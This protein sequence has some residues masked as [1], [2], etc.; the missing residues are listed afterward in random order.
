[1]ASSQRNAVV[2]KV[3]KFLKR[4]LSVVL[5]KRRYDQLSCNNHT[6]ESIE[7]ELN[8]ALEAQLIQILS[9]CNAEAV[10]KSEVSQQLVA[11]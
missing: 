11:I 4:R 7:N 9:D 2:A 6:D 3:A 1:M 5:A 10:V 8:E